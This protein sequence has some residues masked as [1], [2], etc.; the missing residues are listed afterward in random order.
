MR[1][2]ILVFSFFVLVLGSYAHAQIKEMTLSGC[3]SKKLPTVDR[4]Y[5]QNVGDAR[6]FIANKASNTIVE[7]KEFGGKIDS[8]TYKLVNINSG[9]VEGIQ[10]EETRGVKDPRDLKEWIIVKLYYDNK[11]AEQEFYSKDLKSGTT[12]EYKFEYVCNS[13]KSN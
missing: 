4:I 8:F 9:Y 10:N 11:E 13:K 1:I 3:V 12:K 6:I 2:L 7:I 5:N